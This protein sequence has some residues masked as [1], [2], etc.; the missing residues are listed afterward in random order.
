MVAHN[1]FYY[2]LVVRVVQMQRA[3]FKFPPHLKGLESIYLR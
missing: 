3:L 2:S 1:H